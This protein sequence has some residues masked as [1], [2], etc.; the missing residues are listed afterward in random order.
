MLLNR[1]RKNSKLYV[2]L[3]LGMTVFIAATIIATSSIYYLSYSRIMQTDA[4]TADLESLRNMSQFVQGA[5][6]SA[7]SLSFQIYRNSTLAKLLYYYEPNEFD[8]QGALLE[9]NNYLNS[10]SFIESIYVYNPQYERFYV[11]SRRGQ[12]GI[13]PAQEL[14]DQD[15]LRVLDRFD[16]YKPFVPIPRRYKIAKDDAEP[17]GIYTY[18]CYDAINVDREIA[19]AV[20]VNISA[21]W[22]NKGIEAG[23]GLSSR[24]TFIMDD[25][26][27][28]MAADELKPMAEN[29]GIPAVA[30]LIDEGTA[31]R[32]AD[33][34][35]TKS[36]ISYTNPDRFN[37]RY[38]RITPYEAITEKIIGVRTLSVQIAA[39]ILVAGVLLAWIVSF[40]L[41]LPYRRIV[42]RVNDLETEKRETSYAIRQNM[43]RKLF[44][45]Q[46][47]D[48][49]IAQNKL[50]RSGIHFD[51]RKPYRLLHIRID[52]FQALKEQNGSDVQ[53][54]KYAI[55]N[56]GSEISSRH[57]TV[58]TVDVEEDSVLMLLN[59]ADAAESD[60][61]EWLDAMMREIG[62]VC[63]EYFSL[64]LTM[65]ASPVSADPYA[66]HVLYK[67]VKEASRHR[68][69]L[70]HGAVIH[71]AELDTRPG[72]EYVYP[73]GLEKRM[74]EALMTGRAEDAKAYFAEI[75]KET[76]DFP[77]SVAESALSYVTIT[78]TNMIS[79]IQ[80]NGALALTAGASLRMP[81][82]KQHDTIEE[83]S[84]DFCRLFDELIARVAEK[85]AGKQEDL[86]RSI[87][88]IIHARYADP[89]LS[90]NLIADELR[91][92]TFY[93]SRVYRQQTLNTIV[94]VINGVRMDKAKTLL[95]EQARPI[96]EIAELTGYTNSSYFHRMFKKF[97]GVTPAEFRK[98]NQA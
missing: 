37:W 79:E 10:I 2:K 55:M 68:L 24:Q 64:S 84:E 26:K 28:M 93:I 50:Q 88:E 11:V 38:I 59:A 18:L 82:F 65:A 72:S 31:Y 6:D 42:K 21:K 14:N 58:E 33:V 45:M 29:S 8:V 75:M 35:G 27:R 71:A 52:R 1:L 54:Y 34:N 40:V 20:I 76:R 90:L 12:A 15:I 13:L 86:I 32:V 81:D 92:S 91:L 66:L 30:S 73:A 69:F 77:V 47:F 70:G 43:L 46:S 49:D 56:I 87:N 17:T 19:S 39:G 57:Y 53:T 62:H 94:D 16:Q 3:L 96:A 25:H 80:K 85:R 83:I 98:A 23:S 22:I 51:F 89:N 67:Q 4:H 5:T 7:Q 74:V 36:L 97:N 48:P 9:L 60:R 95:L 63:M 61:P 78:L 41:Y 44:Q